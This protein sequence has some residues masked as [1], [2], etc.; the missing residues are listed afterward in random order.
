[1]SPKTSARLN[2]QGS[3]GAPAPDLPPGQSPPREG[4]TGRSLRTASLA[5]GSGLLGVIV[6]SVFSIVVLGGLGTPGD[7][8]RATQALAGSGDLFRWGV[9]SLFLVAVLDVIVAAALLELF[10]P[11]N[12]TVSTLAAWF[13][14]AYAA[15]FLV[16][17]SQLVGALPLSG[18]AGQVAERIRAFDD[19]WHA[20]LILFGV[21]LMLIGYLTYR[22]AFAPRII[23][24]LLVVAGLGYLA[25]SFGVV[26]IPDYPVSIAQFTFVGEAALM[27]WLLIKGRR[28]SM[29]SSAA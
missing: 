16:A 26:L 28:V 1:M 14:T 22:S 3:P 19:I 25:D 6:L 15:V 21:H 2:L 23:G 18:D 13:R 8:P 9:L 17:I 12:R 27:C 10:A 20:G 7:V 11:V 5:A 29:R 24:I 4:G